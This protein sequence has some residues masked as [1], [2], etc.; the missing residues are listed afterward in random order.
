MFT[1]ARLPIRKLFTDKC[2]ITNCT[3][4]KD[5]Y[6]ATSYIDEVICTNEPC[7]ISY[8]IFANAE[9][10]NN[11]ATSITQH[12]K[13]FIREDLHILAGSKIT[14]NRN[15]NITQYKASGVP[16]IYDNHQEINLDL[17]EKYA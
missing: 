16:A 1:K 7:R 9:D 4:T 11:G 3:I 13:L 5:V 6:G 14:V 12:I 17:V 8:S 15:G 10:S 2:T